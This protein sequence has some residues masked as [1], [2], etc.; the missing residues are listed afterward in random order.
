MRIIITCSAKKLFSNFIGL[1]PQVLGNIKCYTQLRM[2]RVTEKNKE[3]KKKAREINLY[4][5]VE[6]LKEYFK[7]G[8][9]IPN[10]SYIFQY[11][12]K[13]YKFFL[14]PLLYD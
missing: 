13:F 9:M 10:L 12:T 4:M 1:T 3:K 7:S 6:K 5:Y 14:D 2:N 8:I 11:A